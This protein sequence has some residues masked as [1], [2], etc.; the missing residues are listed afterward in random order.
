MIHTV[1]FDDPDIY[2]TVEFKKP[3]NVNISP[4]AP[5][6]VDGVGVHYW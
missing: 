5:F 3:D 4:T 1:R 6:W 2:A